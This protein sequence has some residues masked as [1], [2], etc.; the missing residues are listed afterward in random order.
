M[1]R[2]VLAILLSV[3][4]I[5]S[6]E[7]KPDKKVTIKVGSY[8]LMTSDSRVKHIAK[9]ADMSHQRYWCHSAQAVA[10]QVSDLD[11]DIIGL[12]EV[13]D[14]IWGLTGDKGFRKMMEDAGNTQ[15]KWIL[16]PNGS[17]GNLSY[18]VAI[19]YKSDVFTEL[20]SGIYWLAGIFDKS[21]ALP[22]APKGSKRPCVWAKLQHNQ[23]G[24]ILFFFSTHFVVPGISKEGNAYNA[25]NCIKYAAELIGSRKTPSIIV[26]DFNATKGAPGF[27][28]VEGSGRWHDVFYILK[29]EGLLD[30]S[31][32]QKGTCNAKNEQSISGW[33]P[34][35]ITIDGNLSAESFK[36]VRSKYPTT[37]G[38]EHYPSDHFPIVAEL[39][40]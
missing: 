12:Q 34:D 35:H 32:T 16:Y 36:T 15:Y 8:N 2:V 31:E 13:C 29:D 5:M 4:S 18:D 21:E 27:D 7:A 23:T 38:T 26:G 17:K 11:C 37:D 20:E 14:S 33:R 39:K 22:T 25:E 19:G 30:E 10:A 28:V 3:A 1:R 9:N 6:T 24:K 40:F